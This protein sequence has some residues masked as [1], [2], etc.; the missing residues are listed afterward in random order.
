MENKLATP[1][2]KAFSIT[3][4][5]VSQCKDLTLRSIVE[6]LVINFD[7]EKL[8]RLLFG[9]RAS[10]LNVHKHRRIFLAR[11]PLVKALKQKP[12]FMAP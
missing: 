2:G 4:N 7:Q 10:P 12:V 5:V 3:K 11:A 6:T 9:V 8:E 1:L